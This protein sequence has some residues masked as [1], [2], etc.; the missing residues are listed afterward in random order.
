[1]ELRGAFEGGE[2]RVELM[3]GDLF[4]RLTPRADLRLS[5]ELTA[6]DAD[7]RGFDYRL[8]RSRAGAQRYEATFGEGRGRLALNVQAGDV[9]IVAR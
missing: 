4:V 6:G 1:V 9:T 3:A 2:H 5:L 7:L 8:E